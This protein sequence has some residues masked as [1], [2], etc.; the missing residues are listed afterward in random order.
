[1]LGEIDRW[2]IDI[3]RIGD[4]SSNRPLTAVAYAAFQVREQLMYHNELENE[5]NQM[6]IHCCEYHLTEL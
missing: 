6:W 1:M 2:G 4:L 3:F 5:I